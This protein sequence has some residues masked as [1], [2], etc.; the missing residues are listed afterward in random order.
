[1]N[2][3]VLAITLGL[4]A[5][6]AALAIV[7]FAREPQPLATGPADYFDQSAA[8]EDRIRALEAAVAQ[9]RDARLLLEEEL[10]AQTQAQ[11]GHFVFTGIF[12][13]QDLALN[14]PGSESPG[15]RD[16]ITR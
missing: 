5:A 11:V 16:T 7:L 10:Q 9:E 14:S 2:K 4:L 6:F 8:T 3:N 1:M 15:N 13:R 12:S